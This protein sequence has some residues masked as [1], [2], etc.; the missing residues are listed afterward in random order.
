MLGVD[1]WFISAVPS[2]STSFL[3]PFFPSFPLFPT[4]QEP[5]LSVRV[6][7]HESFPPPHSHPLGRAAAVRVRVPV[8]RRAPVRGPQRTRPRRERER[9]AGAR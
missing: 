8:R 1:S 4:F 2:S 9:A 3:S 7:E 6:L 5:W